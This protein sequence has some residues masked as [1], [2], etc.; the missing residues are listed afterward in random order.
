M[1]YKGEANYKWDSWKA[2][3][4]KSKEEAA[5]EYVALVNELIAAK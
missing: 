5:A 4:G 2:N 3:E 1:M